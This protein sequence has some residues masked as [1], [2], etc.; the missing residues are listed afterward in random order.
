MNPVVIYIC[1]IKELTL[2]VGKTRLVRF[3]NKDTEWRYAVEMKSRFPFMLS[4]F[5]PLAFPVLRLLASSVHCPVKQKEGLMQQPGVSPWR[6]INT[7]DTDSA[8][9][10]G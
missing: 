6:N 10:V 7:A 9:A 5:S 4:I 1:L 2:T 3:L 8:L